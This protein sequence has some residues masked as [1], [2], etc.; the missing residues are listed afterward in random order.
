VAAGRGGTAWGGMGV[1]EAL[2]ERTCSWAR[3]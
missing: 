2:F 1:G 3:L